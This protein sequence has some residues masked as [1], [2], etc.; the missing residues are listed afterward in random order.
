MKIVIQPMLEEDI[1]QVM[2]IEEES[3][4]TVW[5][6]N[7]YRRELRENRLAHYIVAVDESTEGA[8]PRGN[9][10]AASPVRSPRDAEH[11]GLVSRLRRVLLRRWTGEAAAKSRACQ[12]LIVGYAGIWIVLDEAHLT[13]I[14]VHPVY[15]GRGIGELLLISAIEMSVEMNAEVMT[16]EVRTS[17]IQAQTLYEKYGFQRVGLRRGYYVDTREDALIMTSENLNTPSYRQ[18]FQQLKQANR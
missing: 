4:P 3:F 18:R 11:Q 7:A 12:R 2:K 17:N 6:A 5:S 9:G 10:A 16:L 14:A 1:P 13:T 15:R 8:E